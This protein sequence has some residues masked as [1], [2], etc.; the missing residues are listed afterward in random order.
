MPRLWLDFGSYLT[1]HLPPPHPGSLFVTVVPRVH[2]LLCWDVGGWGQGSFIGLGV[3]Q[4][5]GATSAPGA[6]GFPQRDTQPPCPHR[7]L[8]GQGFARLAASAVCFSEIAPAPGRTGE[9]KRPPQPSVLPWA[10]PGLAA[11]CVAPLPGPPA[12]AQTLGRCV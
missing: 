10:L 12:A 2:C 3:L 9:Q 1:A 11:L 5:V 7:R 6:C 8:P 4:G